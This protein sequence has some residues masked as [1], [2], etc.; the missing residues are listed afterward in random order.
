MPDVLLGCLS[1]LLTNVCN[2]K[3]A[4]EQSGGF[5]GRALLRHA[6]GCVAIVT[7]SLDPALW[8]PTWQQVG[9][10]SPGLTGHR[11]EQLTDSSAL[12]AWSTPP[13]GADSKRHQVPGRGYVLCTV[14]GA[15]R[16]AERCRCVSCMRRCM[17]CA[18]QASGSFWLSRLSRDR[19]AGLRCGTLELLAR[20]LAPGAR[21]TR[22]V[23]AQVRW[24]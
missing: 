13:R 22:A 19:E 17:C 12:P 3:P 23:V 7:A 8:A 6:V 4:G 24:Q 10:W 16:W 15:R 5:R 20:L 11:P 14:L 21:A 1:A 18:V 9:R 2:D